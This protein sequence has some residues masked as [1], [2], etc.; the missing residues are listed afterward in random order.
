MT[1]RACWSAALLRV[2]LIL[3]AACAH[4]E[5]P[6]CEDKIV[7]L[8]ARSDAGYRAFA[9]VIR[10]GQYDE[11]FAPRFIGKERL[12]AHIVTDTGVDRRSSHA[13]TFHVSGGSRTTLVFSDEAC[14]SLFLLRG[15]ADP[16][17]GF[18]RL[19]SRVG[20]Q[21]RTSDEALA[22]FWAFAELVEGNA[23]RI[24]YSARQAQW[25]IEGFILRR[26]GFERIDSIVSTWLEQNAGFLSSIVPPT[27]SHEDSRF[28]VSYFNVE[29]G[30]VAQHKLVL[31]N[32]PVVLDHRIVARSSAVQLD[33]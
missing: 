11:P 30:L 24:S 8:V 21:V 17:L 7:R 25:Q 10:A 14:E 20:V 9:K 3:Q 27:V 29:S 5:V 16:V 1:S 15:S 31:G 12:I 33:D 2:M 18:N 22:L 13:S 23:D 4:A 26:Q 6:A 19:A 28:T 32:D